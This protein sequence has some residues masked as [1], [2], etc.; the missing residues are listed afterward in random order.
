MCAEAIA[1]RL[2]FMMEKDI[3]VCDEGFHELLNY[4]EPGYC[5]PS[6]GTV[7]NHVEKWYSEKKDELKVHLLSAGNVTF[8][9]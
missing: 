3:V 2:C 4:I 8:N 1:Q 6:R 5:T 7:N 9:L